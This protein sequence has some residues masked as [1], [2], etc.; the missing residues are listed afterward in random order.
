MAREVK[1]RYCRALDLQEAVRVDR[2]FATYN[3]LVI[4][5][6]DTAQC[7]SSC[8]WTRAKAKVPQHVCTTLQDACLCT[9]LSNGVT[10]SESGYPTIGAVKAPRDFAVRSAVRSCSR[11][12]VCREKLQHLLRNCSLGSCSFVLRKLAALESDIGIVMMFRFLSWMIH[13]IT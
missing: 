10:S 8:D 9:A 4:I 7:D 13:I 11:V 5:L 3:S 1:G 12:G 6:M 2:V